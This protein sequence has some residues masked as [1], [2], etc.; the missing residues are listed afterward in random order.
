MPLYDSTCTIYG[1]PVVQLHTKDARY[2]TL[3]C[4]TTSCTI[5]W[6]FTLNIDI[7][8]RTHVFMIIPGMSPSMSQNVTL[9]A[10]REKAYGIMNSAMQIKRYSNRAYIQWLS[11]SIFHSHF[12]CLSNTHNT[13]SKT[14]HRYQHNVWEHGCYLHNVGLNTICI[15]CV[16]WHE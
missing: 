5:C 12:I 15:V 1:I 2:I 8:D 10:Q 3:F 9:G 4:H 13:L 16:L 7:H 11:L 14:S 6:I